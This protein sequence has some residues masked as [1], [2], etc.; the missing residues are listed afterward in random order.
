MKV[1]SFRR[2]LSINCVQDGG[3]YHKPAATLIRTNLFFELGCVD[4]LYV[5]VPSERGM[6][7][8]RLFIKQAESNPLDLRALEK[9]E[10]FENLGNTLTFFPE[11]EALTSISTEIA[12]Y[13]AVH[14]L[15]Y[16]RLKSQ[17][18][19]AIPEA[20][21][22]ALC[23]THLRIF[24]KF[25]PALFQERIDGTTLWN[26][27]DFAALEIL[28]EWRPVLP[29]ISNALSGLLGSGLINHID[30]NI[31]NFIWVESIKRL[32]YV[33]LK[34]TTFISKQSNEHNLKGLRTYFLR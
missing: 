13:L 2:P 22:G 30:W 19:V 23:T 5:K 34:P 20:S 29:Q 27:F 6:M 25:R 18:A 15:Q 14:K 12:H 31:Q 16:E 26:M 3:V 7:D 24:R 10:R 17:S 1:E 8:Y 33:D 21:F 9:A 11:F 28:G 4:D 32:Y